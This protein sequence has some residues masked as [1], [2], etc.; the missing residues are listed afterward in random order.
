MGLEDGFV[1]LAFCGGG[2]WAFCYYSIF[3]VVKSAKSIDF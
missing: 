1:I 2:G 3:S